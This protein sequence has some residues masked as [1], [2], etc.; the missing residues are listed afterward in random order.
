MKIILTLNNFLINNINLKMNTTLDNKKNNIKKLKKIKSI[1]AHNDWVSAVS[2]FPSGKIISVS[3]DK[4]IKIWENSF[5]LLQKINDAHYDEIIDVNIKD[6]N[7]FVTSSDDKHIKTWIK[8]DNFFTIN[9]IIKKAHNLGIRKIIY[10]ENYNIISCS[11][12]KTIKIW[13]F[14]NNKYQLMTII[15][16]LSYV[17]SLLLLKDKNILISSGD[18]GTKF[19]N[20]NHFN[21]ICSFNKVWCGTYNA[22]E[23]IDENRI[24][25]GGKHS[26]EVIS[27]LYKTIIISIDN[28]WICNGIKVIENKRIFL[29]SGWSNDIKMFSIDNYQCIEIIKNAHIEYIVGFCILNNDLIISYGGDCKFKVWKLFDIE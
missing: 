17:K 28:E 9:Q 15:K 19:W 11:I 8:I 25:V 2:V 3:D 6:E 18:N 20:F 1:N 23:R 4:S 27:I 29:V 5:K 12:D 13:E 22:L 10:L 7:N 24:I 14:V 21:L 16:D 26:L